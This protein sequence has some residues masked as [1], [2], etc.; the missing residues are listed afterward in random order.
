MIKTNRS[1]FKPAEK[2][3]EQLPATFKGLFKLPSM[4]KNHILI[5]FG[6]LCTVPIY[7][8]HVASNCEISEQRLNRIGQ[9]LLVSIEHNQLNGSLAYS[10]ERNFNI[11]HYIKQQLV[12]SSCLM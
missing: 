2:D 5:Y 4:L 11:L 8:L 9:S 7:V 1:N 10:V 12:T 3:S 6:M